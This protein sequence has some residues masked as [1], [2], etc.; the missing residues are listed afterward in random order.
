MEACTNGIGGDPSSKKI[1]KQSRQRH[2]EDTD[3]GMGISCEKDQS[4]SS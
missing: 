2:R 1:T 4:S 3:T